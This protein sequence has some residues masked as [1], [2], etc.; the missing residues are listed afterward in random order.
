M[1]YADG[2]CSCYSRTVLDIPLLAAVAWQSASLRGGGGTRTE[3]TK[4]HANLTLQQFFTERAAVSACHALDI[5]ASDAVRAEPGEQIEG[6]YY[7]DGKKKDAIERWSDCESGANMFRLSSQRARL[8]FVMDACA[9][10]LYFYRS[11]IMARKGV[12]RVGQCRPSISSSCARRG[13]AGV[14]HAHNT[15]INLA[16]GARGDET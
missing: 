4:S 1:A 2:P 15:C 7:H 6:I 9:P 14:K 3:D 12:P 13:E 11:A 8:Y 10:F 16:I 5:S